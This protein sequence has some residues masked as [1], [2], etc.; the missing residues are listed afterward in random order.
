MRVSEAHVDMLDDL[1]GRK[2][3]MAAPESLTGLLAE[4]EGAWGAITEVAYAGDSDQDQLRVTWYSSWNTTDGSLGYRESTFDYPEYLWGYLELLPEGFIEG[5]I[6]TSARFRLESS[7]D[8]TDWEDTECWV[9]GKIVDL[10]FNN[11]AEPKRVDYILNTHP[12]IRHSASMSK[13]GKLGSKASL[14]LLGSGKK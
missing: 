5:F 14:Q 8:S 7:A 12:E 3:V 11:E 2:V 10:K 1:E 4:S 13:L 6:G 9:A